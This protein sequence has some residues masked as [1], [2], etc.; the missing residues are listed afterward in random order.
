MT[1][2]SIKDNE[3]D[4]QATINSFQA[5]SEIE[6]MD[7]ETLTY[8]LEQGM[9]NRSKNYSANLELRTATGDGLH[10]I[11]LHFLQDKSEIE[12]QGNRNVFGTFFLFSDF[13]T[14]T[15]LEQRGLLI[16]ETITKM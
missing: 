1:L 12:K 2:N 5:E 4:D 10:S 13:E 16:S 15:K 6:E 9:E 3:S 14:K 11:E 7:L 8:E